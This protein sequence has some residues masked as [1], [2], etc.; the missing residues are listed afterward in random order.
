MIASSD[1]IEGATETNLRI[2]LT[3]GGESLPRTPSRGSP[4]RFADSLMRPRFPRSVPARSRQHSVAPGNLRSPYFLLTF[5][6]PHL[7]LR[8]RIGATLPTRD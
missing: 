6:N 5:R 7:L 1:S 2:R 4:P 8:H 3:N